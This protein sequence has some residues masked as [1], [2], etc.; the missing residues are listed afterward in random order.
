LQKALKE[1]HTNAD[2]LTEYH[3]LYE[4]QR[5]RLERTIEIL[6]DERELWTK[7]A[8]NISLKVLNENNLNNFKRLNIAEKSWSKL[9]Q[10]CAI[11]LS[12]NDIKALAEIQSFIT[13][14]KENM[15]DMRTQLNFKEKHMSDLLDKSK[16]ELNN[17]KNILRKESL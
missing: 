15:N 1:A 11:F 3:Q 14:W 2:L 4:L 12:D 9:C 6:I 8:Y 10:H 7:A 5:H 16:N 17:L 13:A